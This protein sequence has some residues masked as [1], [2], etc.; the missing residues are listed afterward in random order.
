MRHLRYLLKIKLEIFLCLFMLIQLVVSSSVLAQTSKKKIVTW[1]IYKDGNSF[2][3]L[4][5][6]KDI[7]GSISV[8]G[9]P[10]KAFID[11]CHKNNIEVYHAVSGDE[12]IIDSAYKIKNVVNEYINYCNLNNYD[13]IDLDFENL[14][15]GM[16]NIYSVF[17][18]E[19]STRLHNAGKKLSHCVGFYPDLYKNIVTGIFYDP[20]VI[21]ATC[22]LV[23]VMCY[24]MYYA[25]GRSDKNLLNRDDCQGIGP[26]SN[27]SFTKDAMTYW[28]RYISKDKLVMA[29]PA[30]SN[31]YTLTGN[32]TGKQVYATVPDSIRGTLPSPTWQW[33]EKLNIYLYN[34]LNGNSHLFFACDSKSTKALLEISDEFKIYN[35]G[36]WHLSSVD[37]KTWSIVR[38]WIN[39]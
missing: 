15:P 16:Q 31:D 3:E 6:L 13:G 17:L 29:L 32:G 7:I 23:R 20:A 5:P 9:N 21:A 39:K 33:Y 2:E 1:Y 8:F 19:A 25:P 24:D 14:N 11:E 12:K 18:K 22:D 34:D 4:E 37:P 30:Y 26:T 35:I 27:Y 38:E 28:S 10:T 36:F